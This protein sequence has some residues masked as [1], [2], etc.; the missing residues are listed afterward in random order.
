MR[1]WLLATSCLAGAIASVHAQTA[2][3]QGS[4][5][6]NGHIPQYYPNP[7]QE[8]VLGDGGGS[9]GGPTVGTNPQ[10]LGITS[11]SPTNAYPVSGGGHGPNGEHFCMYDAPVSNPSG[12]HYLC[13][14]PNAGGGALLSFGALG[15][16]TAQ[17][18]TIKGNGI[19]ETFPFSGGGSITGP[20][21]YLA[22]YNS[23]G[24]LASS[25][26]LPNANIPAFTGQVT[27]SAGSNNLSLA[28]GA[29]A[30]NLG[31]TPLN[32]NTSQGPNTVYSGPTVSSGPPTFRSLVWNDLP[33]FTQG[34]AHAINRTLLSK[35]QETV[36]V[37]DW[38]PPG[39]NLATTDVTGYFQN[40]ATDAC[41]RS[42]GGLHIYV[43]PYT[44]IINGTSNSGA[45]VNNS[46]GNTWELAT[47][48]GIGEA[49]YGATT[50]GGA[51][52]NYC[53]TG[54]F[55]MRWQPAGF[56]AF[57]TKQ[58]IQGGGIFGG[59]LNDTCASNSPALISNGTSDW[60]AHDLVTNNAYSVLQIKG[61]L[62]PK[63]NDI[64]D[65]LTRSQDY[66]FTGD[67]TGQN[68]NGA[69][70]VT[71]S[72]VSS[73]GTAITWTAHGL[74]AN[75][76]LWF[77][78]S[79][80]G[81]LSG[82]VGYY[83]L[84]AGLTTNSF[85]VATSP[86]GSAVSAGTGSGFTA[87]AASTTG[88]SD[89]STGT[90]VPLG[91][92]LVG[93][94][95]KANDMFTITGA[96]YTTTLD[97][98]YAETPAIGL[99]ESCPAGSDPAMSQC[100]LFGRVR[101]PQFEFYK[102]NGI[103]MTDFIN[104]I[105]DDPYL[106]GDGSSNNVYSFYGASSNYNS[107]A[108][109]SGVLKILHGKMFATGSDCIHF[110]GTMWDV[111]VEDNDINACNINAIGGMGINSAGTMTH[112]KAFLN[113]IGE[114]DGYAGTFLTHGIQ[115]STNTTS[116]LAVNNIISFTSQGYTLGSITGGSG[117]GSG[118]VY[119]LVPLTGGSGDGLAKAKITV[120]GSGV[121]TGVAMENY[122]SGYVAS[123]TLSAASGNIGG[124]TGFSVPISLTYT[125][126]PVSNLSSN[127][128]STHI[129]G[130]V[131]SGAPTIAS[132]ACGSGPAG[133]VSGTD[134]IMQVTVGGGTP[135][136]CTVNFS[137]Q[138]PGPTYCFSSI[139]PGGSANAVT[140]GTVPGPPA[141]VA[142]NG[143]VS[144]TTYTLQCNQQ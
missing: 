49:T 64:S 2:V 9:G 63:F 52:I 35:V 112:L 105:F 102:Y 43:P 72:T 90:Y 100:P 13:F 117:G 65:Y 129:Q 23:G 18:L 82:T 45:G 75:Q 31:F 28:A 59:T 24:A 133:A 58:H 4:P 103:Y 104:W 87:I 39:T 69:P 70:C 93:T 84:A 42:P 15:G 32:P 101:D 44:Y 51:T 114:I 107:T 30:A 143:G 60:H 3:L 47:I 27:N 97:H 91:E 89:C 38:I 134:N 140:L 55:G 127:A 57:T 138:Q 62:W 25:Q 83:V 139:I 11:Y 126:A 16:A 92:K 136:P 88:P 80:P 8:P 85:E 1:K 111:T 68:Q 113:T 119:D 29:A 17:P 19:S 132:G 66:V 76:Y 41:A 48:G 125:N 122:G 135:N 121:V 74:V 21:N 33:L 67:Q 115:F 116:S 110:D 137:T 61:S 106:Y 78:G 94:G 124:V 142:I 141:Q 118:G 54:S 86:G 7:Y 79:L 95:T 36:S 53:L 6:T 71:S 81:G 26:Y 98:V 14:D 96:V 77:T 20:P 73:S 123:D 99:V 131:A 5:W 128:S 130:N 12:F 144:G 40:A 37:T 10:E 22:V 46:C 56:P 50:P 109:P 34:D 120:N 108:N